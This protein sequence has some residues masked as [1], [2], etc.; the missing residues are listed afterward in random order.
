M[1]VPQK[2]YIIMNSGRKET[3]AVVAVKF[4]AK[5]TLFFVFFINAKAVHISAAQDSRAV[6][7][8]AKWPLPNGSISK[9]E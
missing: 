5:V 4:L 6:M 3:T 9:Y 7:S 2:E 8:G 1:R